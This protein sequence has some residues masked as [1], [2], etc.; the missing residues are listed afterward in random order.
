MAPN[1]RIPPSGFFGAPP[2]V[3]ESLRPETSVDFAERLRVLFR[4]AVRNAIQQHL[5][6]GH[7]VALQI[8]GKLTMVGP[9]AASLPSVLTPGE[10]S[11]D[12]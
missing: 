6:S 7:A 2:E 12:H 11:T 3:P 4:D 5:A 9:G 1:D 8:N 10:S